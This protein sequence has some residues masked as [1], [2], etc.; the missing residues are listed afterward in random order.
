VPWREVRYPRVSPLRLRLESQCLGLSSPEDFLATSVMPRD[1][2]LVTLV[3]GENGVT[4]IDTHQE[5]G[6]LHL[7]RPG[8][9]VGGFVPDHSVVHAL[10]YTDKANTRLR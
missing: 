7:A 1:A 5:L 4:F 9:C 10:C 6:T 3:V 2:L 8:F